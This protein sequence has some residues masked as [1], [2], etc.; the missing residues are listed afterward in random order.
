MTDTCSE[1]KIFI[2]FS[3]VSMWA[4]INISLECQNNSFIVQNKYQVYI[5]FTFN[6]YSIWYFTLHINI[7]FEISH[8]K[9]HC[10]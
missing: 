1:I 4:W 7:Q 3:T 5:F 8:S 2:Y 9:P 6:N 10:I